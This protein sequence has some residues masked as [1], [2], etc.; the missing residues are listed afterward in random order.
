M[1]KRHSQLEHGQPVKQTM[2]LFC[3][4]DSGVACCQSQYQSE[5]NNASAR[6]SAC[7]YDHYVIER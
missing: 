6:S 5:L 1:E 4:C 7:L 2:G 3:T